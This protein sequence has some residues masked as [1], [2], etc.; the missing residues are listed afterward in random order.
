MTISGTIIAY[1]LPSTQN[2]EE[3]VSAVVESIKKKIK[4]ISYDRME[5]NNARI[6]IDDPQQTM[7]VF[8]LLKSGLKAQGVA[9]PAHI[10]ISDNAF[11]PTSSTCGC[12]FR[13]A[14]DMS[15]S[16]S[17]LWKDVKEEI[18]S[19]ISFT[20]D[21]VE[22]WT[23]RQATMFF[24]YCLNDCSQKDVARELGVSVQAV[25]KVLASAKLRPITTFLQHV[26]NIV[27]NKL[28]V[29]PHI[30]HFIDE[31]EKLRDNGE[32]ERDDTYDRRHKVSTGNHVTYK[33]KVMPS[34]SDP[35]RIISEDGSLAYEFL[36][37]FDKQD[38]GYG[39]YFGCRCLILK[40]D[41]DA[42]CAYLEK[43]WET[44]KSSAVKILNDT[45]QGKDFTERFEASQKNGTVALW[46]FWMKLSEGEDISVA[47]LATKLIALIYIEYIKSCALIFESKQH[48]KS[49]ITERV[50]EKWFTNDSFNQV[51]DKLEKIGQ[52][53]PFNDFLNS[54]EKSQVISQVPQYER[55]FRFNKL[56]KVEVTYF[57]CSLVGMESTNNKKSYYGPSINKPLLQLEI[58]EREKNE[59]WSYFSPVFVDKDCKTLGNLKSVMAQSHKKN[60]DDIVKH[61]TEEYS[62]L[63]N[64][65][66]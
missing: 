66:S 38:F 28:R 27:S 34:S 14:K 31:I 16:V 42:Q 12:D 51:K 21:I 7:D 3:L 15:T 4:D 10:D 25:S 60:E 17:S 49:K 1:S 37:E 55:C 54:A 19:G 39:L 44:V 41:F 48:R 36:I 35:L 62:K 5:D 45:F 24:S 50:N 8:M 20:D 18:L 61:V 22:C 63:L 32:Y 23:K 13:S 53:K 64:P 57:I 59:Y 30:Q 43:E 52:W 33:Y 65:V 58:G 47:A 26:R 11:D 9:F 40:G 29:V 56:N 6:V 46:P 2:T